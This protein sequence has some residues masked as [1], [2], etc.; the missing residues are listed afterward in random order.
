MESLANLLNIATTS[1]NNTLRKQA[2][3]QLILH[4]NQHP[5][6]LNMLF[7]LISDLNYDELTRE[8]AALFIHNFTR[9]YL[10]SQG[11]KLEE[12]IKI[13]NVII[14]SIQIDTLPHKLKLHLEK[15]LSMLLHYD[16]TS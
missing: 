3:D 2:E 9:S 10:N 13:S 1:N 6:T 4:A 7:Q 12:M 11:Y 15:T 8:S 16:R 5:E 14:E